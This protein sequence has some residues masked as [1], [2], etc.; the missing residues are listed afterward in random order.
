MEDVHGLEAAREVVGTN[1]G[2]GDEKAEN[3]G[4]ADFARHRKLLGKWKTR[5]MLQGW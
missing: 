3:Q 4:K 5:N 2:A 1:G